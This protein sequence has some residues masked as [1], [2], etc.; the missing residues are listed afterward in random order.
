[1]PTSMVMVSTERDKGRTREME[2]RKDFSDLKREVIDNGNCALCGGC[3]ATCRLLDYGL[4]RMDVAEGGPVKGEGQQYAPAASCFFSQGKPVIRPGQQCPPSCGYCYY[5]CPRVEAPVLKE[6]LE[7]IYEVVSKDETIRG[8]CH[9]GGA[10]LSLLVSALEDAIV[11]GC[12]TIADKAGKPEVRVAMSKSSLIEGAGSCYGSAATLTGVADAIVNQGLWT[13]ALVGTPCQIA[14]YEKMLEVGRGTHNAHNFSS[15]VRLRISLFCTGAYSYDALVKE[16]L[17]RKQGIPVR[18]I[19]RLDIRD[20]GL[21]VYAGDKE[22]FHAALSEIA[23]YKR[24]GCKIC[25]DFAGRFSD[26]SVGHIGTPAGKSTVIIHTDF[27]KEVFERA[28]EWGYID[29][30][31]IDKAGAELIHRLQQEKREAGLAE[32]AK[33]K[34]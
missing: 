9:N 23:D 19:T 15:S 4:L 24:A 26:I 13:V 11:E 22:L 3:V 5:Q 6:G 17:E 8:A 10:L 18:E 7:E 29:A 14:G 31:P 2:R 27:G 1:M 21:H 30:K 16:Y 28:I 33:R 20:D 32:K 12:I 25:E 34:D